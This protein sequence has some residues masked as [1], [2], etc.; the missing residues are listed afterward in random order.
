[1]L[2]AAQ[3]P[4]NCGYYGDTERSCTCGASAVNRYQRRVSGPLLDRFD[5]HIDVPRVK[6]EKLT[7]ERQ[8][9]ASIMLRQRVCQARQIQVERFQ[10]TKLLTNADMGPAELQI[11]CK[12]TPQGESLIK[13]A[14]RQLSLSARGYHRVLKLS[15]TIADLEAASQIAPN[16]LAEAIQYRR[17]Q[18]E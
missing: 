10:G 7:S 18:E 3:N 15:R 13:A 14:V 5:I 8:S 16:H 17:R 2:L 6:Y 4:C 9:E 1:M 11:Y 12:L